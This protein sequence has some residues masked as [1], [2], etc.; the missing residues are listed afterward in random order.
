MPR[1][2]E[3]IL[4]LTPIMAFV[5]WRLLAPSPRLPLG[6]V[7]GLTGLVAVMLAALLWLRH[8]EAGDADQAYVPAQ[9]RQGQI[10]SPQRVP[11]P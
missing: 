2:I 6:L 7:Y 8:I 11:R 3:I 5:A 9:L 1:I 10:V 4:F